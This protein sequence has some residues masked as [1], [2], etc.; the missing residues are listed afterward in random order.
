M[1]KS[2]HMTGWQVKQAYLAATKKEIKNIELYKK[3]N[4]RQTISKE[5]S[6]VWKDADEDG[7]NVMIK[8]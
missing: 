6:D 5:W 8:R 1:F 2:A 3:E 4:S 7:D